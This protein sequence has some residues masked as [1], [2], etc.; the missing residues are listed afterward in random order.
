MPGSAPGS[1]SSVPAAFMAPFICQG[2]GDQGVAEMHSHSANNTTIAVTVFRQLSGQ[3]S[4]RPY[5]EQQ[6]VDKKMNT[7][8]F[9]NASRGLRVDN[10]WRQKIIM[11]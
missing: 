7:F 4:V 10:G 2:R 8:Y 1:A 9:K 6:Q 5:R 3:V 11:I